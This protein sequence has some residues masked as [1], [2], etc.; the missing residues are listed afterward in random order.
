MKGKNLTIF[1]ILALIIIAPLTLGFTSQYGQYSIDRIIEN[2]NVMFVLIFITFFALIFFTLNKS[3]GNPAISAVLAI[4]IS[5]F[6][7]FSVSQR[8]RFYGYF[9]EKIGSFLLIII[10]AVALILFIKFIVE[11][12]HGF[13]LFLSIGGIWLLLRSVE[14][15]DYFPYQFFTSDFFEIWQFITSDLFITLV[16]SLFVFLL[17]LAHKPDSVKS[18]KKFMWGKGKQTLLQHLGKTRVRK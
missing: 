9:G 18:V 16:I 11:I 4:I 1:S 3:M 7:S 8:T 6:I 14:P 15:R 10:L 5:I 2:P 12:L 13:G 17:V